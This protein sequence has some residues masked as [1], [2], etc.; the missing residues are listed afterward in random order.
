MSGGEEKKDLQEV[1][2]GGFTAAVADEKN[3]GGDNIVTVK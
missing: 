1:E 2:L 3:G